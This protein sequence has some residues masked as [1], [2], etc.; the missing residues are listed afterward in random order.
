MLAWVSRFLPCIHCSEQHEP[1]H[2]AENSEADPQS[3]RV[4]FGTGR[5]F[6]LKQ[7]SYRP[8]RQHLILEGLTGFIAP[9]LKIMNFACRWLARAQSL[10]V[11]R[12]RPVD[13]VSEAK[14]CTIMICKMAIGT[15]SH[16]YSLL[17][18]AKWSIVKCSNTSWRLVNLCCFPCK[19]EGDLL[20]RCFNF[21]PYAS[22]MPSNSKRCKSLTAFWCTLQTWSYTISPLSGPGWGQ[23]KWP[24]VIRRFAI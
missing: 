3:W 8:E 10:W 15:N 21:P 12:D 4:E 6:G 14:F 2:G 19:D 17:V 7:S 11:K 23:R 24:L 18:L 9:N 20:W 22:N 16:S 5:A 13:G 1:S